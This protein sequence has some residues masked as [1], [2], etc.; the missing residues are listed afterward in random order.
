MRRQAHPNIATN[1]NEYYC[2]KYGI[3]SLVCYTCM[4]INTIRP[5]Y[6]IL[7]TAE[8]SLK[9]VNCS[10]NMQRI[11]RYSRGLFKHNVLLRF[12]FGFVYTTNKQ[13]NIYSKCLGHFKSCCVFFVSFFF[14]FSD[15]G[16]LNISINKLNLEIF[17]AYFKPFFL[18]PNVIYHDEWESVEKDQ[19]KFV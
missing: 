1:R 18:F 13:T 15:F 19:L 3:Y 6:K 10:P 2:H 12:F 8:L 16:S 4:L 5:G 11:V 14:F 7:L 9:Y 17:T